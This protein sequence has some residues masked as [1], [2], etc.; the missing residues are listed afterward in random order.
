[1]SRRKDAEA[2]AA[3]AESLRITPV[4]VSHGPANGLSGQGSCER[5][6]SAWFMAMISVRGRSD[7]PATSGNMSSSFQCPS[8]GAYAFKNQTRRQRHGSSLR[9]WPRRR[10][11]LPTTVWA[12]LRKSR[13]ASSLPPG[14]RE[15]AARLMMRIR[16]MQTR[17]RWRSY[18]L[19][20]QARKMT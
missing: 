1:M 19:R 12:L 15:A 5:V 16:S 6:G 7:S 18:P 8:F 13:D 9:N 20:A 17:D 3:G 2:T 14:W 11:S 10:L 4:A